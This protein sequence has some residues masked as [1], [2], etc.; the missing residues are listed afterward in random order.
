MLENIRKVCKYDAMNTKALFIPVFIFSLF[1]V[2]S[3]STSKLAVDVTSDAI[4]DG[5]PAFYEEDDLDLARKGLESNI[6][7]LEVLQRSNPG[8]ENLRVLLAQAYGGFAFVFLESDLLH[9]KSAEESKRLIKRI[10]KFY[11][12]GLNYGLSILKEDKRFRAALEKN[13]FE[14]IESAAFGITNREALL[15][16]IFNWALLVNMNRFNVDQVADYSKVKILADRMLQLDRSYFYGA[17]LAL[18]ATLECAMPKML[19][20]K[21]DKG[22]ALMEEA[23]KD[24]NRKFLII[25][26]LYAQYCTPAVQNRKNFAALSEEIEKADAGALKEMTLINVAVKD[27]MPK[28]KRSIKDFF[29][30]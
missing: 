16:T 18:S 26:F 21:P 7:L 9:A 12:R 4:K 27:R 28:V 20:G 1:A 6:K 22:I 8:N 14:M 23:L 3:C 2:S 29:E 17:P 13:D 10:S 11:T 15:W 5:M 24:S 30:D 19:G 25:Q